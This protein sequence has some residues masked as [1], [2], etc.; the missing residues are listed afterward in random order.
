MF[1]IKESPVWADEVH[2]FDLDDPVEGGIDGVDNVPLGELADRTAFLRGSI[3]LAG[4]HTFVI[5]S[6]DA[7]AAWA[8]NAPGND[9]SR[10]LIKAGTWTLET[11]LSGGTWNNPVAA[12]DISD[13]R[14]LSVVGEAGSIVVI[15]HKSPS[16]HD[17]VCGIKGGA[18]N[19]VNPVSDC[20]IDNVCIKI[21]STAF[22][23]LFAF[24]GCINLTNCTAMATAM[25]AETA[26]WDGGGNC[27]YGCINLT[28]CTATAPET[29]VT[30]SGHGYGFESC[31]NLTNCTAAGTEMGDDCNFYG[32][33]N[34]TNCTATV[35]DGGYGYGFESCTNLTNCTAMV[36][37][38]SYGFLSCRTGF[39]NSG[40][41]SYCFME[42]QTGTTPWSSTASGGYNFV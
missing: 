21:R 30:G 38:D 33:T 40:K 28:N 42:Q 34:L 37:K 20:F 2:G 35:G 10:I 8:K 6:D 1:S 23:S 13:G 12:I 11:T 5:D 29:M 4:G 24:Y 7:L 27:F 14:T 19:I 26:M 32:C 36:P 39:G 17:F 18:P 25:G 16:R 22:F 15:D 31:T 41:A 9:Y 3:R